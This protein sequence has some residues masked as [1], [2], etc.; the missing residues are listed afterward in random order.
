[1]LIQFSF[2]SND[3]NILLQDTV[4]QAGLSLFSV[5][6]ALVSFALAVPKHK[7]G[8]EEVIKYCTPNL[9][10]KKKSQFAYK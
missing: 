5:E 2:P 7:L 6:L 3:M 8:I 9:A 10:T 1:M 4:K